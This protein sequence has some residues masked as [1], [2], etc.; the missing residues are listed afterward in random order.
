VRVDKEEEEEEEEKVLEVETRQTDRERL[1]Q[2]AVTA[3]EEEIYS[4]TIGRG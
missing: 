3:A 2:Q 1:R 4:S